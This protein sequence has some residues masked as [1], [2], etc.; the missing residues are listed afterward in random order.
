MQDSRDGTYVTHH[1]LQTPHID[2]VIVDHRVV[3]KDVGRPSHA[4]V[5]KIDKK[6]ENDPI[7]SNWALKPY[8][9]KD[10]T[11]APNANL[12]HVDNISPF[13][14]NDVQKQFEDGRIVI[15]AT[16][17]PNKITPLL[18]SVVK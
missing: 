12:A 17:S 10:G 5:I 2:G 18:P 15:R 3:D 16:K 8:K 13:A 1:L 9:R 6:H 7:V 4:Y 14:H 11:K